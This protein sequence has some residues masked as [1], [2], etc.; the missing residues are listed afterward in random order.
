MRPFS[1][2]PLAGKE[3]DSL[4]VLVAGVLVAGVVFPAYPH[5]WPPSLT[6]GMMSAKE[7]HIKGIDTFTDSNS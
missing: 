1:A 4:L 5:K 2:G 6:R 3:Q 7:H